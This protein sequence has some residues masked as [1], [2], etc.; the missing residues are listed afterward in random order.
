M[1]NVFELLLFLNSICFRRKKY[2]TM[3]LSRRT[4]LAREKN[5]DEN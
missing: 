1:Q 5:L 3:L 4:E 2:L